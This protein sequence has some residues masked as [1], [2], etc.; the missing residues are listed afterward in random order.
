MSSRNICFGSVD[1]QG[2]VTVAGGRT[3][4]GVLAHPLPS[5]LST[6]TPPRGREKAPRP[7]MEEEPALSPWPVEVGRGREV[8]SRPHPHRRVCGAPQKE[9]RLHTEVGDHSPVSSCQKTHSGVTFLCNDKAGGPGQDRA[10]GLLSGQPIRQGRTRGRRRD[11]FR[12]QPV[13]SHGRGLQAESALVPAGRAGNSS[14]LPVL[15]RGV[16]R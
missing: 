3:K 5:T 16:R 1:L 13:P 15:K 11:G 12:R 6:R 10:G 9:R 14:P 7:A 4:A 8:Q 2:K